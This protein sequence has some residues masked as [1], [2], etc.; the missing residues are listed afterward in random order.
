MKKKIYLCLIILCFMIGSYSFYQIYLILNQNYVEKKHHQYLSDIAQVH[1]NVDDNLI[2]EPNKEEIKID[3]EALQ[4]ENSDII[5]WLQIPDTTIDYAI[6]QGE[7]NDYYLHHNAMKEENYAGAIFVDY[8]NKTPFEEEHTII[9]GHNVKHGTM[10]APLESFQEETFF[11]NHPYFYLYTP[12]ANYKVEIFA[13]Y[14]TTATSDAYELSS[15]N[16]TLINK[17]YNDSLYQHPISFQEEDKII[18]L[19]T[20]SYERNNQPSELR[21]VLKGILRVIE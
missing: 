15:I 6:V 2:K 9:Y 17:W 19:S 3:F 10:F 11:Q 1:Q 16:H 21:H 18:T 5:A 12:K 20:C 8:R 14:T 4:A 13:F 7:D